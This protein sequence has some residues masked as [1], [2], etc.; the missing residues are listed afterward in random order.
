MLT[1]TCKEGDSVYVRHGAD[2]LRI[3]IGPKG[4]TGFEGP[5]AFAIEREKVHLAKI[6]ES[7]RQRGNAA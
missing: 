2:T 3:V 1:L 7:D 4:K 6:A 5:L